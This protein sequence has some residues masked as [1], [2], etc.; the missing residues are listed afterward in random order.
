MS[1]GENIVSLKNLLLLIMYK[2]NKEEF[3]SSN[4]SNFSLKY[5]LYNWFTRILYTKCEGDMKFLKNDPL[6]RMRR[7]PKYSSISGG[8]INVSGFP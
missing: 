8:Y 3:F 6:I 7:N 5:Y 1:L 2:K 4:G